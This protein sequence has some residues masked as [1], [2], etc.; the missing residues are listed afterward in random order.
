M[1]TFNRVRIE[2]KVANNKPKEQSDDITNWTITICS[3]IKGRYTIYSVCN[4]MSIYCIIGREEALMES[5]KKIEILQEKIS[6][7][8]VQLVERNE[9]NK[10]LSAEIKSNYQSLVI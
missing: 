8:S 2:R 3:T 4:D 9:A 5:K 10:Q 7:L 1:N 6:S